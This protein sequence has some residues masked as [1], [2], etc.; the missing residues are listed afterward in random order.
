[1]PYI[2]TMAVSAVPLRDR[3]RHLVARRPEILER[4]N[5]GSLNVVIWERRLPPAVP[6][7]LRRWADAG[8]Q[9]FEGL[10]SDGGAWVEAALRG[11]PVSPARAFLVRDLHA[12]VEKFRELTAL[13]K[14]KLSFGVVTGDQCRKFHGDY[15]RLR[16]ITTYLGPATEWLPERA[17]RREALLQPPACPTTANH[18]IVRDPTQVRRAHAGDVLLLRGHDGVTGAALG[19]VHRSP[20]IEA[21]RKVRVVLVA[22]L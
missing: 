2:A 3:D 18:L 11:F 12:L 16:L 10:V 9:R 13:E 1:M 14:V 22:S 20:P 17:V 7:A 4:I 6:A 15:N 5:D 8:P 21:S 19:A